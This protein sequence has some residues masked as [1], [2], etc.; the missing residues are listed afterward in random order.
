MLTATPIA[1]KTTQYPSP[2]LASEPTLWPVTHSHAPSANCPRDAVIASIGSGSLRIS[3]K[4][5]VLDSD[6]GETGEGESRGKA[7]VEGPEGWRDDDEVDAHWETGIGVGCDVKSP[8]LVE[9]GSR[10]EKKL[11]ERECL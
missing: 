2:V 8:K 4:G 10:N 3:K 9:P 7:T 5:D 6:R 1:S 11:C